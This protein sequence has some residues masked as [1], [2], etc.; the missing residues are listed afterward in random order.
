MR[1]LNTLAVSIGIAAYNEEQNIGRLLD[2]VLRQKLKTVRVTEILVISSGSTDNTNNIIKTYASRYKKIKLIKQTKRVGKASAVNL[3]LSRSQENIIVLVS[4]DILLSPYTLERLV[5]PLHNPKTGITGAHPIPLNVNNNFFGY[6]AHLQWNL[7]H[8][9][10]INS[11]K[12]GECIAF[13]KVF[14]QIHILTAVDEVNIESLVRGQGFKAVYVPT[15]IIYNKGAENLG[16]FIAARR[17]IYVGHLATMN[18]YSYTVSTISGTK[19]LL[20]LLKNFQFTWR[21]VLWTPVIILLE[22]YS[23]LLG[24]TDYKLKRNRHTIWE[25]TKSTKQLPNFGKLNT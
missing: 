3:L 9:M 23:R 19:I 5:K 20:L 14:K 11:P 15:A 1:K 16:D 10:S 12:M 13:R 4:A 2:S 7:H 18:E 22:V 8:W 17:R 6:A 25:I 24:Y 21:S